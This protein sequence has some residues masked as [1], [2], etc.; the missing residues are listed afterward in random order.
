MNHHY[1][2]FHR[3]AKRLRNLLARICFYFS[4]VFYVLRAF[5]IAQLFCSY[6]LHEM[7]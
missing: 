6:L 4:L 5:V 7:T 2:I 3:Y 1:T